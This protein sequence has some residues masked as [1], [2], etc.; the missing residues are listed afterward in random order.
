MLFNAP[1]ETSL[2]AN[3]GATNVHASPAVPYP[4]EIL[5]LEQVFRAE[6]AL[7]REL[8]E[9]LVALSAEYD[10]IE[11]HMGYYPLRIT[12]DGRAH[13]GYAELRDYIARV[14]AFARHS[15]SVDGAPFTGDLSEYREAVREAADRNDERQASSELIEMLSPLASWR[16]IAQQFN[17]ESQ[18]NAENLKCAHEIRQE[19]GL[20]GQANSMKLVAGRVEMQIRIY[21]DVDYYK[22]RTLGYNCSL[23]PF[24][25]SLAHACEHAGQPTRFARSFRRWCQDLSSTP[26]ES[27]RRIDLGDGVVLVLG[28]EYFKLYFPQEMAAAIN[29]FLAEFPTDKYGR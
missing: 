7:R 14:E 24:S 5:G 9:R 19:L 12:K 18:R 26:I 22:K 6:V 23:I 25:H 11:K 29:E 10:A 27:R 21:P 4:D 16:A 2:E 20:Y 3:V 28:Y 8:D 13:L 1:Q 17:P 15:L